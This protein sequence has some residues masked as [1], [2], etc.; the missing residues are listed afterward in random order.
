MRYNLGFL[1]F[2]TQHSDL[3]YPVQLENTSNLCI[4]PLLPV[5][6]SLLQNLR[7][8]L[9]MQGVQNMEENIFIDEDKN[10]IFGDENFTATKYFIVL[11]N[12]N[13]LF[14]KKFVR[15]RKGFTQKNNSFL[16]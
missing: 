8:V 7:S 14:Q 3:L 5:Y 11:E 12:I 4:T 2:S 10:V 9:A 16:A 15:F 1:A 13:F 6:H